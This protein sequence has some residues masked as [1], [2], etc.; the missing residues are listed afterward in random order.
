MFIRVVFSLFFFFTATLSATVFSPVCNGLLENV[1][2]SRR[3]LSELGL[4]DRSRRTL[5]KMGIYTIGDL[6]RKTPEELLA[7]P[8]FG[9]TTLDHV[10]QRL[11]LI[12]RTLKEDR[13]IIFMES[14]T[15]LPPAA[16]NAN[17]LTPV[18]LDTTLAEKLDLREALR[19]VPRNGKGQRPKGAPNRA[20]YDMAIR[21]PQGLKNRLDAQ[22]KK[23]GVQ[24]SM[25][26][27]AIY[28]HTLNKLQ[29]PKN[30]A[31]CQLVDGKV[32]NAVTYTSTNGTF[33]YQS[34]IPL[35]VRKAV[36]NMASQRKISFEQARI[37][38]LEAGLDMLEKDYVD[39]TRISSPLSPAK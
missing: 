28:R 38:L 8:E 37:G 39:A 15:I 20:E 9:Y 21:I 33:R 4:N 30:N 31:E 27:E 29:L 36:E 22:A 14:N 12:G 10:R 32:R 5:S 16:V 35:D 7:N 25:V 17:L 19:A 24:I 34:S 18:L 3:L 6:A 26:V 13:A 2:I 11:R 1:E 23:Y